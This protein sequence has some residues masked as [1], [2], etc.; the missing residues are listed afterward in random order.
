CTQAQTGAAAGKLCSTAKGEREGQRAY[1]LGPALSEPTHWLIVGQQNGAWQILRT[2]TITADNRGVPG[3][4]WALASGA[5]VVVI[6]TGTGLN[7]REG[8][9]LGQKAVDSLAD[10]TK[11]KLSAGPVIADG[12]E[13]WQVDGRSGWVSA[14]Y[15]R[16][17]DATQ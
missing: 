11:I 2:V 10:G 12:L 6:G 15:L 8:P 7:V 16:Y 13:W 3:T 5:Q 4:P 1:I 17:P 9:A 14:D